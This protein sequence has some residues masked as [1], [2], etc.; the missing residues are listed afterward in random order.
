MTEAMRRSCLWRWPGFSGGGVGFVLL[1]RA[2]C[3]AIVFP[4]WMYQLISSLCCVCSS[5]CGDFVELVKLR[6]AFSAATAAGH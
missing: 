1:M 2:K 4:V 3:Q 6:A 5:C